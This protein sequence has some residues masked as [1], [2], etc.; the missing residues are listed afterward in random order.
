[1][2]L[3]WSSS[4]A[5]FELEVKAFLAE[6]L[7]PELRRAALLMTSVYA[8]HS[9]GLEWQRILHKRG[10]VAPAWPVEYGGRLHSGTRG[11]VG[12]GSAISQR[13]RRFDLRGDKRDPEKHHGQ[14]PAG[15]LR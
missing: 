9:V 13:P 12:G 5:A 2:N 4:D 10:W 8:P 3:E 15:S 14:E 11:G 1:M 6:N 7:S